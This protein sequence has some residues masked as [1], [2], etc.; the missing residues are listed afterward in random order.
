MSFVPNTDDDRKQMLEKIGV[1][2]FEELIKNIP[3]SIR[4]KNSLDIPPKLSE[5]EVV[6]L[7]QTYANKNKDASN[8]TCYLGGGAYDHF[9][10]TIV[11]MVLERPEFKTAY[12]PYQAEVSQGTLQAMYEYQSM[13][14]TLTGMDVSNASLYDGGSAMAEA[15]LMAFAHNKRSKF[16]YAGSVNPQYRK[17]VSTI[18]SGKKLT[19]SEFVADDGTCDLEG[20]KKAIDN[21]V[22]AVIVQ[23]PNVY[24]NLEDVQE[25]EKLAHSAGA[26]FVVS[27]DPISLG[28]LK[29]PGEYNAD[30]VIGEGQ[31]LGIPLSYGGPYL[32]LF[33]AKQEFVR[34]IP[35]RLSGVTKDTD[36]KRGFVLTLQTREQQIKREK[37]TSNICTNQGLFM[38]AATAYMATMGK[39]GIKEAAE[40][41]LQKA[42]Y[43]ASKIKEI[44]GFKLLSDKPFFKEF[45]V[46]TPVPAQK[47]IEECEKEGI[48]AGI[49]TSRFPECKQGLLIAV[50]EKRS[51]DELDKYADILKRFAK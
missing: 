51:K 33:A 23:Q 13:I 35:G 31:S 5:Y 3:D 45:L 26:L 4:F 18:S 24:G 49:D 9:I 20:L 47:I 16:I 8:Y 28:V 48:L 32:G 30:V 41:C 6:K 42:H 34:K 10:P 36:G 19:F 2:S 21:N 27:V 37:A 22:S 50:T 7:L 38:L 40:L 44:K 17:V 29:A 14:C 25:I 11:S 43:L 1:S 12:T 39:Q 15:V 46:K